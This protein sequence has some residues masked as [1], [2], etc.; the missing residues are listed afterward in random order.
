MEPVISQH[1]IY[2]VGNKINWLKRFVN[3]VQKNHVDEFSFSHCS[4]LK[5]AHQHCQENMQQNNTV[6]ISESYLKHGFASSSSKV[7]AKQCLKLN[8]ILAGETNN[9]SII[10]QALNNGIFFFVAPSFNPET[11]LQ[12]IKSASSTKISNDF[13]NLDSEPLQFPEPLDQACFNIKT[14][15]EARKVARLLSSIAP[16]PKRA[17]TGLLELILNAIEHGNL[18]IGFKEKTMLLDQE[19]FQET[20]SQKLKSPE[21]KDKK[22]TIEFSK[23]DK[24]I[25][26]KITDE[27]LGFEPND[28]FVFNSQRSL[29]KN[30]RGILIAKSYSFD[31]LHYENSGRT[32]VATVFL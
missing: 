28:F 15:K 2:M 6:I 8:V 16:N 12:T 22:V 13:E 30:G 24:K 10:R 14:P 23:S 21:F 32:A 17:S 7:F 29:Q 9:P 20:V 1:H 19:S 25:I 27:G 5:T 3:F 26:Y 4:D 31:Q 18:G 11:I